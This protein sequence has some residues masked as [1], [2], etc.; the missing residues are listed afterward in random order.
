[1]KPIKGGYMRDCNLCD[2][3]KIDVWKVIM[4]SYLKDLRSNK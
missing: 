1:M 3:Q 4:L 2:D